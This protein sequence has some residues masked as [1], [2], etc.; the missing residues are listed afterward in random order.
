MLDHPFSREDLGQC[1]GPSSGNGVDL[2]NGQQELLVEFHQLV[3]VRLIRH[4]VPEEP[5]PVV[6]T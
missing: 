3:S 2:K 1:G 5:H 6:K 4:T